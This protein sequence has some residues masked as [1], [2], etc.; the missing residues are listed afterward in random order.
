MSEGDEKPTS[1]EDESLTST[2]G[3]GLSSGGG[4][5]GMNMAT[6]MGESLQEM[7]KEAMQRH[8]EMGEETVQRQQQLANR[9]MNVGVPG[10]DTSQL[11]PM[12]QVGTFKTRVQSNGRISIPDAERD[13]LDIEE[14]DIVQ[15]FVIPV[16]RSDT[17]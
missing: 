16:K 10:L 9:M 3:D 5:S 12:N 4:M 2:E 15:T 6:M 17:E 11:G 14:G 8:V 7:S 1:E 13:A